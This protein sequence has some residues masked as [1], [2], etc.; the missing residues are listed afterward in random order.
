MSNIKNI[1]VS[2]TV[3]ATCLAMVVGCDMETSGNGKLDGM[4]H[5]RS[6]DTLSTG[7]YNDLSDE[8]LYWEIQ[9]DLLILDDKSD[10]Y[11]NIV[12]YFD[13]SGDTLRLYSPYIYN[14]TEGD[15]EIESIDQLRPYGVNSTD[16]SFFIQKLS[17]SRMILST[18]TLQLNFK[19]I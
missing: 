14:R 16:E 2:L 11:E 13:H 8:K 6:V 10:Y 7:G 1:A 17:G 9:G 15:P 18:D 5:L 4:W 3:A 19:K 12:M